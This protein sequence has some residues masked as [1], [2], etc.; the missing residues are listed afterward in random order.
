MRAASLRSPIFPAGTRV[1]E[2]NRAV[3]ADFQS[4]TKHNRPTAVDGRPKKS[5]AADDEFSKLRAS[6]DFPEQSASFL[7]D[8]IT[9]GNF[10]SRFSE[11]REMDACTLGIV[12][13]GKRVGAFLRCGSGIRAGIMNRQTNE[14][15]VYC[16]STIRMG[17][18]VLELKV[19]VHELVFKFS[20]EL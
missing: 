17:L 14:L 5:G 13:L 6:S 16:T 9:S 8:D 11:V 10:Y 3:A 15:T 18:R 19:F 2:E 1:A 12:S 7:D 4:R 20:L